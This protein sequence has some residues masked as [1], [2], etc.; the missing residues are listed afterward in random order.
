MVGADSAFWTKSLSAKCFVK[1]A[2]PKNMRYNRDMVTLKVPI[3]VLSERRNAFERTPASWTHYPKLKENKWEQIDASWD[4]NP[5]ISKDEI[6]AML[7]KGNLSEKGSLRDYHIAHIAFFVQ[8]PIPA[9]RLDF[10]TPTLA[11]IWSSD[12]TASGRWSLGDGFHRLAAAIYRGDKFVE[13]YLAGL[14]PWELSDEDIEFIEKELKISMTSKMFDPAH[15]QPGDPTFVTTALTGEHYNYTL[16]EGFDG[17]E[18]KYLTNPILN[19]KVGRIAG[20]AI[21][22]MPKDSKWPE[23]KDQDT[24]WNDPILYTDGQPSLKIG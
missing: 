9:L 3:E 11:R 6:A 8:N 4:G 1:I 18:F 7:E 21:F 23:L 2:T 19:E 17:F 20:V 22:A 10:V 12:L 24:N 5:P 13:C 15:P 14:E 16:G